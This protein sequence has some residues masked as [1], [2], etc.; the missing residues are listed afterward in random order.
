M[1][2]DSISNHNNYNSDTISNVNATQTKLSLIKADLLASKMSTPVQTQ[3]Q[4]QQTHSQSQPSFQPVQQTQLSQPQPQPQLQQQTSWSSSNQ[5]R[6]D[7]TSM[8]D[9]IE[10]KIANTYAASASDLLFTD[11]HASSDENSAAKR[12]N[13][14]STD[15]KQVHTSYEFTR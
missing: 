1:A 3:Q 8:R 6:R 5:S 11:R 4:L 14:L 9:A 13:D 7:S 15:L 10:A 2:S 12:V